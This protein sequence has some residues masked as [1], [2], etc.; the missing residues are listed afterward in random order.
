MQE[1]LVVDAG[2]ADEGEDGKKRDTSDT[3][4]AGSEWHR[5]CRREKTCSITEGI[6]Y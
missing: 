2:T 1:R 5:G 3:R 6:V 4:G